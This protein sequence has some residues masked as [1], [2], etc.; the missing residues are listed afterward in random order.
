MPSMGYRLRSKFSVGFSLFFFVSLPLVSQAG[1]F[2]RNTRVKVET[3]F[4]VPLNLEGYDLML[5]EWDFKGRAN[6]DDTYV[7]VFDGQGFLLREGPLPIKARFMESAKK[8]QWQVTETRKL[9]MFRSRF[10]VASLKET[11]RTAL[12]EMDYP[13]LGE[14]LERS[15]QFLAGMVSEPPRL[16]DLEQAA[17]QLESLPP[18][19]E[20]LRD[21]AEAKVGQGLILPVEFASKE[22][23]VEKLQLAGLE[24]ELV[25]GKN[26]S[27]G[28]DGLPFEEYEIEADIEGEISD[29]VR[30]AFQLLA[31]R[32]EES[33]LR[34]EH[35]DVVDV[36]RFEFARTSFVQG[37]RGF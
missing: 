5:R 29:N 34:P 22:R 16:K 12:T 19:L 18:V 14:G 20:M 25:L 3:E 37:I 15:K 1:E 26:T 33:G 10:L 17:R 21:V 31:Q 2:E 11:K 9:E 4:R 6:R 28:P 7:E 23:R 35:I 32:L 30:L 24:V 13:D 36:D 27:R 8:M